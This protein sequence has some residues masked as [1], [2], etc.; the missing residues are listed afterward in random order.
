VEPL[1]AEIRLF[2]YGFAPRGWA[3]CDGQTLGISSNAALFSLLGTTYG[4]DGTTTFRLPDLR[5]RVPVHPD[6]GGIQRGWA[7]GAASHALTTA[8]MP[9]HIHPA[10]AADAAADAVDPAGARWAVT[11]RPHYGSA[12]QVA[13]HPASVGTAGSGAPHPNM[14]PY[15]TLAWAIAVT[16]IFPSRDDA[17]PADSLLGEVRLFAGSFTPGGWAVCDGQQLSLQQNTALFSLIGTRY[18]GD[19]STTFAVPDLRGRTPVHQDESSA[20][21]YPVG[22]VGGAESVRL[23]PPQLPAHTHAVRAAA[24]GARG[25]SGNPS[26]AAWAVSQQGRTREALYT[27]ATASAVPM[28][29][30]A[31]APAG[32]DQPH[33]NR[34]PYLGITMIMSLAGEFPRRD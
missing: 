19:G 5:H 6:G 18:G 13:M 12:A 9:L 8:E 10:S 31:V 16:G 14:P 26:G 30:A 23:T 7:G 24:G 17:V 25:T 34:A 21:R 2:P 32:G 29:G 1:L 27:T 20:G 28:A 3:W 4:G 22:S 33:T 11:G 15:L